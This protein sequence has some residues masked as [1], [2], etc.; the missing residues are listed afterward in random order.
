MTQ[1]KDALLSQSLAQYFEDPLHGR[2][3]VQ[4]LDSTRPEHVSLRLIDWVC[5][6]Y[7]KQHRMLFARSNGSI[8]DIHNS[9][10]SHLRSHGKTRFDIFR[11]GQKMTTK[12]GDTEVETTLAQLNFI[13]WLISHDVIWFLEEHRSALMDLQKEEMQKPVKDESPVGEKKPTK[14]KK[15]YHFSQLQARVSFD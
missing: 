6:T 2:L 9:Y 12:V 13:R 3:L 15:G 1:Q 7:S 8:V 10:K 14:R 4:I 11:R 5:T